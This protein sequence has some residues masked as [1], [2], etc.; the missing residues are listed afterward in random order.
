MDKRKTAA[1]LLVPDVDGNR[2]SFTCGVTGAR[3]CTEH[4]YRADDAARELLLAWEH[5]GRGHFNQCR[6]CGRWVFDVA[7]NPEVL[8]CI[9]CAPFECEARFCKSCGARI[10][11]AGG[12][13]CPVCGKPLYYEGVDAYDPKAQV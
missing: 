13:T 10:T 11:A 4:A 2:Y 8:E 1:Y 7:F 5:E 9:E 6:K 12:R 3:F